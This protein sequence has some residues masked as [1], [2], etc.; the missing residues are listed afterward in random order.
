[1]RLTALTAVTALL[2]PLGVHAAAPPPPAEVAAFAARTLAANCQA[3]APGMAVLVARADEVLFRDACG[4]ASLELDVP[5][6]PDHVFRIGSVTKQFAAAAV[7]KLAED[8]RLSLD[9]PL[10]RFL[11]DY[12]GGDAITVRMLLDHTSGIRSYTDIPKVMGEGLIMQDLTTARLV[13]SFKDEKPDFAPGEGWHYNNSG[14]VLVGAVIEAASGM[15][16]HAYLDQAFFGPLGMTRT[17]YGNQAE[18]VIPGHVTG[19]TRNGEGWATARHLSMTQP[20]AAGALVS[21]VDDL[22]RW[23]RALHEGKVLRDASHRAMTTPAGKAAEHGYGFGIGVGTLRGQPKL[24]HGG[25]IFG[26]SSALTYLPGDGLTVAVLYNADGARPGMLGTGRIAQ[27]LAAQAIGRPYP[28]KIPIEVDETTLREY[29]GVYRIDAASARVLRV[30]DGRLTSQRTDGPIY[31]LLPVGE[32][33]F[34]FEEGFSRVEF[35][36][37]ANGR[38]AAMRYFP[39]DE[40]DGEVVARSDE[41]LPAAR[42]EVALG[43]DALERVTGT[44]AGGGLRLRVFL[45]DGRP[46]A[47]LA[48][49]PALEI[50]AESDTMFF[51]KAVEATLEF[52]P[53]AGAARQ[54]TLRQGGQQFVLERT[55]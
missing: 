42:E 37:D 30:S 39:E 54:V 53:E 33:S 36:R 34:A 46:Y 14:Y 28:D 2:L 21:T 55:P 20:H 43:Q 45:D 13:D 38:V 11:P 35:E 47:E 32:D 25:G 23:N 27:L 24:E 18:A 5:L 1:M 52:S 50:F 29:E 7:L 41:P 6:S 26:F 40:G 9:D 8:G 51:L 44:Y 19:Y 17:G 22:L 15:P 12:P 4:K 16:W 48:G 3:D 49:Q 10:T 31:V